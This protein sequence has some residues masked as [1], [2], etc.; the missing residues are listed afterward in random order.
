MKMRVLQ[1][2]LIISL[3][4][5]LSAITTLSHAGD[6]TLKQAIQQVRKQT[7]GRILDATT[8]EIKGKRVHRIKV[9]TPDGRVK[10]ITIPAE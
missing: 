3:L 7:G 2:L 6:K 1:Y 8:V 5:S 10:V 9:L 4:F